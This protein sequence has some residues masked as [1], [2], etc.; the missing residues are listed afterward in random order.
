MYVYIVVVNKEKQI[1]KHHI[2]K[3]NF[4]LFCIRFIFEKNVTAEIFDKHN[5]RWTDFK[6]CASGHANLQQVS[7]PALDSNCCL[8]F[9]SFACLGKELKTISDL[10][11]Q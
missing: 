1:K 11:P 5:F 7:N 2:I 10:L 3:C 9:T 6:N 8:C 4:H